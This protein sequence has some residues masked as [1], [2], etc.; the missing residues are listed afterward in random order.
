MGRWTLRHRDAPTLEERR[1]TGLKLLQ[2]GLSQAEV[3]RRLGVTP[4]AVCRWKTK[5]DRGGSEALRAIP[6]PGRPPRIPRQK[7]ATLPSILAK[8]ALAYGFSTD[9]WTIPRIA[10][11]TQAEW[12]TRYSSTEIWRL[13]KRHGLSWQKPRRQAR[14]K[15]LRAVRNWTRHSWSRYKKKPD[16]SAPS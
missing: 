11:V 2:S 12:G 16:D 14:E 8:G 9:L 6:R 15:D 1:L 13:L 7:Q 10:K 5:S 3:A 4:V